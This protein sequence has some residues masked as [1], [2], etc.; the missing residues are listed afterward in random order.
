MTRMIN[1]PGSD[2]SNFYLDVAEGKIPSL[3]IVSKFGINKAIGTTEEDIWAPGGLLTYLTTAATVEVV[4]S[5]ANDTAAGTGAREVTVFGLDENWNEASETI[6]TA[7]TSASSATTTTFI[8]VYRVTVSEIGAYGGTNAGNLIV[9]VSGGGST[10]GYILAD[11]GQSQGVH[12]TIP[13]GHKAYI[14]AMH[15]TIDTSKSVSFNIYKRGR[16][17]DIS[18]PFS[19]WGVL[20][21]GVGLEGSN[22]LNP[23]APLF[24]DEYTDIRVAGSVVSGSAIGSFDYQLVLSHLGVG[25]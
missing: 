1:I 14:I 24:I 2:S 16:A 4:S 13:R 22:P 7:G 6:A 8:R 5:D 12:Y 17:N 23:A 18:A 3:S 9:R 10:Q 15:A 19:S 20:F 11:K 21:E 25:E